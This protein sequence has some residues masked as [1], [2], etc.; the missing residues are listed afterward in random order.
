MNKATLQPEGSWKVETMTS[1]EETDWK[2]TQESGKTLKD[3]MEAA[4]TKKATET[5]K[6]LTKKLKK[7]LT[8][9]KNFYKS[10]EKN[11]LFNDLKVWEK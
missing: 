7:G 5:K 11:C 8:T 6:N 3:N 9:I 2:A 10:K 1:D 4:S